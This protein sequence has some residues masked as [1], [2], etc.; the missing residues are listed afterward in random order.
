IQPN[1]TGPYFVTFQGPLVDAAP[2]M[3]VTGTALLPADGVSVPGS[4]LPSQPQP[5]APLTNLSGDNMWRGPTTLT[6]SAPINVTANSRLSLMGTVDDATNQALNGSAVTK[7]G[8]G[9]MVLGGANTFQG[10]THVGLAKVFGDASDLPGGTLTLENSQALGGTV[11][12]T[13]VTT[14]ATLQLQGNL[15]VAAEPPTVQGDGRTSRPPP[16]PRRW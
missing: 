15:P 4:L 8:T 2:I 16:G 13:F 14:G 3:T 5:E 7:V 6:Q 9:E 1:G 10:V 11:N 12:G